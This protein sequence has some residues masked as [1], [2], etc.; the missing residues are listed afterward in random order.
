[1]QRAS[2][3]R[4]LSFKIFLRAHSVDVCCILE[5]HLTSKHRFLIRGYQEFRQDRRHGHKGGVLTLVKNTISSFETQRS[6]SLELDTA[7]ISIKLVETQLTIVN[8]YSSRDLPIQLNDI[9]LS[10]ENWII[11]GDF[12]SHSPSWGYKDIDAR[13]EEVESFIIN[14]NL[15]LLNKPDDPATFYSRVWR[16]TSS[17]DLAIATDDVHK[18][19]NREVCNQLGGSDH[20]PV[21]ITIGKTVPHNIKYPPSWNFKKA[22]WEVFQKAMEQEVSSLTLQTDVN[23]SVAVFNA[24]ILKSAKKAI[25]RGRRKDYVPFWSKELDLLHKNLD[26]TRQTVE[27]NPSDKNVSEYNR[28][29]SLYVREKAKATR[30]SWYEKTRSL[31][32]EKNTT[33]LWRLAQNLNGDN[34]SDCKTVLQV[35]DQTVTGKWAANTFADIYKK[36]SIIHRSRSQIKKI[37]KQTRKILR[38]KR[39]IEDDTSMSEEFSIG[40]LQ[41]ALRQ[42]RCKKAPGPDGIHNEM[43]K[44]L[45]PQ[46]KKFLLDVFNQSWNQ[47]KVP[48]Q[49]KHAEIIPILKK[50]KPKSNPRSYRPISLLSCMGKLM[51]RMI[52]SRL[53]SHLETKGLLTNSQTGYRKRRNT[54]DQLAFLS[55][56]IENAFQRKRSFSQYSL[57][58][59][60][61]STKFGKKVFS[62]SSE[63]LG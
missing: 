56:S 52:N 48:K 30:G 39:N 27:E 19:S 4:K 3:I 58:C 40:E 23:K 25:P 31:D 37:R 10:E 29:K 38:D 46:A 61:R 34:R 47:G 49:W 35:D 36:G 60:V 9:L 8:I 63:T 44:H 41:H 14:N 45:G 22:N 2:D 7:F 33:A 15:I 43:L 55:Q 1:M 18:V 28:A 57:T 24:A 59:Q 54:E 53:M 11:V 21:S 50:G 20:R 32:M 12:N 26:S 62:S 6:D 16:S 5:T 51:E 42:I 13:G 17:P